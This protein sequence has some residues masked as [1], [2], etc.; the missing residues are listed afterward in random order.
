MHSV[1]ISLASNYEAKK[2]L[3]EARARLEQ[4]LSEVTYSDCIRTRGIGTQRLCY[5]RNQLLFGSTTLTVDELT[6]HL[7]SIEQQMGRTPEARQQGIVCIDL[8]LLKYDT[9]HYHE[10]DWERPYVRRLLPQP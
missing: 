3:F 6:E 10:R 7:K 2:N 1:I 4:I 8:D 9:A 5:Y